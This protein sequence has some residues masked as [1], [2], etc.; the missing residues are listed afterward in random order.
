MNT[1]TVCKLSLDDYAEIVGEK[2]IY[3]IRTLS[4]KLD[5]KSIVH[6]N[7]TSF[8]GGVA[9]ILHRLVPLMCDLG[10]KAEWKVIKGSDEFFDVTK[11]IHNGLQGM[12]VSL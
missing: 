7:S 12:N 8:G 3:K 10:L 5:G 9:E 1:V 11:T 4:E 6:V 2:E